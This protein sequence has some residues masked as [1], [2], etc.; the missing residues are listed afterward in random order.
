MRGR[1]Y[2]GFTR[3]RVIEKI[4]TSEETVKIKRNKI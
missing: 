2:T 3:V 4:I 1:I